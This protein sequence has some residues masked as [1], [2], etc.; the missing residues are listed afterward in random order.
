MVCV[1]IIQRNK[2]SQPY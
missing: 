1:Q 2:A